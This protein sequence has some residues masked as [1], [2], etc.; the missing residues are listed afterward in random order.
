MSIANKIK[1]IILEF[2]KEKYFNYLEI[3]N[4]LLINNDSLKD[5]ITEFYNNNG[6]PEFKFISS[7]EQLKT[8]TN[9]QHS[10]NQFK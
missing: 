3:N 5:I 6:Y 7:I 8:N 9:V 10:E 4:F 1:E 2:I